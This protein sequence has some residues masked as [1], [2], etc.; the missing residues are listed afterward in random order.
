MHSIIQCHF[1]PIKR[2]PVRVAIGKMPPLGRKNRK[3]FF[4][5]FFL[6]NLTIFLLFIGNIG[7]CQIRLFAN[8]IHR[9]SHINHFTAL[10]IKHHINRT[11]RRMRRNITIRIRNH[12]C[13]HFINLFLRRFWM[14]IFIKIINFFKKIFLN[15]KRTITDFESEKISLFTKVFINF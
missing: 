1:L 10:S 13:R 5:K 4:E 11:A 9:T 15:L 8:K 14:L 12:L 3:A 6:Q 7:R 2:R